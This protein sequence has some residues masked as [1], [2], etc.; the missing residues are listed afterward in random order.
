LGQISRNGLTPEYIVHLV[1]KVKFKQNDGV[2]TDYLPTA[3]T[4]CEAH[5]TQAMI[6][7]HDQLDD[8]VLVKRQA[9]VEQT[10][11]LCTEHPQKLAQHRNLLL[12]RR[13]PFPATVRAAAVPLD[14]CLARRLLL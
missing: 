10:A 8:P 5:E 14:P 4:S 6:S 7:A 11:R 12:E 9:L 13:V 3:P 2:N 1:P